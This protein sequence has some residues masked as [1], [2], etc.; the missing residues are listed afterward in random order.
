MPSAKEIIRKVCE[1]H[2]VTFEDLTKRIEGNDRAGRIHRRKIRQAREAI[3]KRLRRERGLSYHQIGLM[4]HLDKSHVR[5][6]G[7]TRGARPPAARRVS[8]GDALQRANRIIQQMLPYVGQ[9]TLDADC[10]RE[11]ND[12]GIYMKIKEKRW[13]TQTQTPPSPLT[14][15]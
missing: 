11:I 2:N 10:L 4:I 6:Y 1:V 13:Q 15:S 7:E 14:K 12:H 9:M 3:I 8:L 5:Y